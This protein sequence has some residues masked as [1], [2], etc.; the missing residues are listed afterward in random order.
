MATKGEGMLSPSDQSTAIWMSP[1]TCS[2]LT[3]GTDLAVCHSVLSSWWSGKLVMPL[4][5]PSAGRV[6]LAH[7]PTFSRMVWQM[8]LKNATL[9]NYCLSSIIANDFG[10][11]SVS[12][13]NMYAIST[14]PVMHVDRASGARHWGMIIMMKQV[15]MPVFRATGMRALQYSNFAQLALASAGMDGNMLMQ[16]IKSQAVFGTWGIINSRTTSEAAAAV[17]QFP[18]EQC[19]RPDS[20]MGMLLHEHQDVLQNLTERVER[21]SVELRV[22]ITHPMLRIRMGLRPAEEAWHDVVIWSLPDPIILKNMFFISQI[23]ATA[24]VLAQ[25][26][27]QRAHDELAAEKTRVDFLLDRQHQLIAYLCQAS[28]MPAEGS[29]LPSGLAELLNNTRAN[30]PK[31]LDGV[32]KNAGSLGIVEKGSKLGEGAYGTVWKGTWH[33][34]V[35]AI[36]TMVCHGSGSSSEKRKRMALMEAAISSSLCH[37]NV[38]QTYHYCVEDLIRSRAGAS[39]KLPTDG[40]PDSEPSLSSSSADS[41]QPLTSSFEVQLIMEFCDGGSLSDAAQLGA[42]SHG[43]IVDVPAVVDIV[44]GVAKGMMHLHLLN[45]I[46]GDLKT[47]NVLLR[48]DLS[49]PSGFVPKIADFGLAITLQSEQTHVSSVRHGTPSH[50]APELLVSGRQSQAADVYAF[51]ILMW[52]TFTGEYA[53][54]DVPSALLAHTVM[55]GLRPVFHA[56]APP[57]Y[58]ALAQQCWHAAPEMRPRFSEVVPVL[59]AM[60]APPLSHSLPVPAVGRLPVDGRACDNDVATRM[61]QMQGGLVGQG[62]GGWGGSGSGWEGSTATEDGGAAAREALARIAGAAGVLFTDLSMGLST[63]AE[64]GPAGG[65]G[66]S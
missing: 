12:G 66:I 25:Q 55:K 26:R 53:F 45:I 42:L 21:R 19:I 10:T 35:V 46:H 8:V 52:E 3:G 22:A 50:M 15:D 24:T 28:D 6:R 63:G 64:P 5:A 14:L 62:S 30:R 29:G 32:A 51:G 11:P 60:L 16:N 40:L 13:T 61:P 56:D 59:S 57:A 37:P 43:G 4:G 27:Q 44:A 41:H 33:G 58:A 54:R 2:L 31:F 18:D 9:G 34:T 38:V 20:F 49:T 65:G 47:R 7:T 17:A 48:S 36:K 1:V 39:V 23:D